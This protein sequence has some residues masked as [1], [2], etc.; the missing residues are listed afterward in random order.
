MKHSDQFKFIGHISPQVVAAG[1]QASVSENIDTFGFA[2]GRLIVTVMHGTL[3][4][5]VGRCTLQE[6]DTSDFAVV[7][8]LLTAEGKDADGVD[9]TL[10]DDTAD[11]IDM[12]F[13][14]PLTPER[15]RYMR[16]TWLAAS[17]GGR[18]GSYVACS[19]ILV[20]RQIGGEVTTEK[21]TKRTN[22]RLYRK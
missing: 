17:T 9:R 12:V 13:D 1:A 4:D 10:P 22:S 21:A 19:A 16:V 6:S 3:A 14:V 20:G 7:S 2:G 8:S 15:K 18:F 5:S 11:N